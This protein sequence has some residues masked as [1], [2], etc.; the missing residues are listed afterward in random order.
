[1]AAF[2]LMRFHESTGRW[3]FMKAKAARRELDDNGS[4]SG[5][6]NSTGAVDDKTTAKE[7]TTQVTA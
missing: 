5:E 7:K 2:I 4:R 3:P 6:S 1:M